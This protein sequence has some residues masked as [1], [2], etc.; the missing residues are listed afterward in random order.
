MRATLGGLACFGVPVRNRALI[1]MLALLVVAPSAQAATPLRAAL[2]ACTTGAE[3]SARA[4]TFVGSMPRRGAARMQM[5]FEL[6]QRLGASGPFKRV[7]VPG[8]GRWETAQRGRSGFVFT[9]RVQDLAA[10]AAYRAIVRF[11]WRNARGR[12]VQRAQ[13][14]SPVC[15]QPDPRPDLRAAHLERVGGD[16]LLTIRNLG[17]SAT[18][19]FG[20][21]LVVDGVLQAPVAAGPILPGGREQVRLDSG[22]CSEI[23]VR[24]DAENVVD[25]PDEGD[26]V[27]RRDCRG[28]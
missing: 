24:V 16:W 13:R 2:T 1:C 10:P 17:G 6:L 23:E 5:R 8:W 19:A 27:L 14:R 22:P 18:P 21:V 26:N 12:V 25:E 28:R 11:R 15:H 20:V 4:A 9:K 3:P 7:T